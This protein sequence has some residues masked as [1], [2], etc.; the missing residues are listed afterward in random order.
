VAAGSFANRAHF[1]DEALDAAR[2]RDIFVTRLSPDGKVMWARGLGV[3]AGDEPRAAAADPDGGTWLTGFFTDSVG[4]TGDPEGAVRSAGGA[5]AF[6]VKVS[7]EGETQVLTSLGGSLADNGNAIAL[8]GSGNVFVAGSFQ[9]EMAVADQIL[10]S[11][12]GRDAFVVALDAEARPRWAVR[13][14]GPGTDEARGLAVGADGRIWVAGNFEST[15]SMDQ[16]S[17]VTSRGLTDVFV[18]GLDSAGR[19]ESQ[20]VFGGSGKERLAGLAAVG[21][22]VALVGDFQGEFYG[23]GDEALLSSAGGTDV[24]VLFADRSGAP[25]FSGRL[26]GTV[27]DQALSAAPSSRG[28]LLLGGY[29]QGRADL[30]PGPESTW[31]ESPDETN[32]DGFLVE[33]SAAGSF[34]GGRRVGGDG[35]EQVL[36]L[37]ATVDGGLAVAGLFK[38][39][40]A[41]DWLGAAVKGRGKSDVFVLRTAF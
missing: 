6:V 22:G 35:V 17:P 13:F 9:G 24:F 28:G 7:R 29:F 16:G 32:A 11:A 12:G 40:M 10:A 23:S 36:A 3:R 5:D 31:V 33:L 39:Q 21:D 8:D 2:V 1:G 37:T 4:R 25:G 27:T 20:A 19:L 34:V 38:G 14:G 30:D 18:L 26:G 41:I 15:A